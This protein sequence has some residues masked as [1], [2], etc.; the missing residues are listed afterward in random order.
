MKKKILKMQNLINE[1]ISNIHKSAQEWHEQNLRWFEFNIND[2]DSLIELS[3]KLLYHNYCIWHLIEGYSDPDTGKVNF[4]YLG[5]LEHNKLRNETIEKMD[6][7]FMTLQSDTGSYNSET[8]GSVIDRI[9]NVII[10][11]L[12]LIESSDDRVNQLE[13]QLDFLSKAANELYQD[14]VQGNRRIL[15][16][17]RFKTTGYDR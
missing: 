8:L 5:G 13:S 7:I 17:K 11:L 14:M 6:D 4:V 2:D 1:I 16:I 3:T 15:T 9:S 12:H 10:K